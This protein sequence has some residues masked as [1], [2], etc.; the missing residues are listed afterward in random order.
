DINDIFIGATF[1]KLYLY[2]E[3]HDSRIVFISNSM[4]NYE[5]G[6]ELYKFLREISFEKTKFIQPIT[7][8][9]IDSLPFC[10]RIIYKNI[11]LK[12]AT[13]KINS[14]MFSDTKD[15]LNRF[16]TIREKWHIPKDVIIAFGDNRLL[17]NL[18][19]DKHI[20]I[21]KKELKKHGR[22]R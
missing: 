3:K 12:P 20:I 14:E 5:F 17:L 22:I 13:W 16:T 15:W 6:S 8:E 7:E 2:S 9:G 21:L 19:N 10:P 4:F 18:L 11:I 1:N